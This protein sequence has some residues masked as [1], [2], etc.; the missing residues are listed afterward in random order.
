MA[1]HEESA[2][3]RGDAT[4]LQGPRAPR[5]VRLPPHARG[6]R[7]GLFGGSFNPPHQGHRAAS[8][9]A[10]RRLRLDCVWWL[11][12]PGNPLKDKAELAPLPARMAAAQKLASHPRI[13][14]SGVEAAIGAAYSFETIVWLKQRCPGVHFVWIIGA[15]NLAA[16]HRWKR[17]RDLIALVPIAVIDRPGST[18]KSMSSQVAA[19]LAPH[20]VAEGAAAALATAAPPAFVFLHGPRSGLSSTALRATLR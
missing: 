8:L 1:P 7:I 15:D 12:T 16:L 13:K 19:A 20:R 9:L 11:V 10:L 5:D 3:T 18:L 4:I 2:A 6:M 17:W 14:I